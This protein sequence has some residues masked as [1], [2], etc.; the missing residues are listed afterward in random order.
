[1][2]LCRLLLLLPAV[3]CASS[4]PDTRDDGSTDP[5][6]SGS[7]ESLDD[8]STPGAGEDGALASVREGPWRTESASV[9]G[10]P[11]GFNAYT[12]SYGF[13][14]VAYLPNTFDVRPS[15]GGFYIEASPYNVVRGP[16]FCTLDGTQFDCEEQ[17]VLVN[18]IWLYEIEFSGEQI[19]EETITGTALV[20]FQFDEDTEADIRA[21]GFEMSECDHTIDMTLVYGRF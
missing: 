2:H 21:A 10:D 13:P 7:I 16:I 8:G 19:D 3:G 1:M 18:D 15:T 14:I 17:S 6:T 12:A 5:S 4:V 9:E 20:R 11:C